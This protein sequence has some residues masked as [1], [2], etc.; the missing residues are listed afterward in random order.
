M[1]NTIKILL[2]G[3]LITAGVYLGDKLD[4]YEKTAGMVS[5]SKEWVADI[6]SKDLGEKTEDYLREVQKSDDREEYIS[7]IEEL[8][9]VL[10]DSCPDSTKKDLAIYL[11]E[12]LEPESQK[13]VLKV[14][15]YEVWD[16]TKTSFENKVKELYRQFKEEFSWE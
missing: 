13:E 1:K 12:N 7:Q 3:G 8:S 9:Y 4:V 6:F 5:D 15:G 16:N 10:I 11:V 2:T 14:S